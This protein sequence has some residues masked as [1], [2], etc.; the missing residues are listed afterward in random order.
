MTV[1][2]SDIRFAIDEKEDKWCAYL[3][4]EASDG[5]EVMK[6]IT[7]EHLG[8]EVVSWGLDHFG[9][10]A[11]VLSLGN[12]PFGTVVE[13][14]IEGD[15]DKYKGVYCN[16][17]RMYLREAHGKQ[18]SAYGTCT[19]EY[20]YPKRKEGD[21]S[22]INVQDIISVV[23][24][25]FKVKHQPKSIPNRKE[26]GTFYG[27]SDRIA[28]MEEGTS[29]CFKIIPWMYCLLTISEELLPIANN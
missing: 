16:N 2:L 14:P 15:Y 25:R 28:V 9:P 8:L 26:T 21:E 27:Q 18:D 1:L 6:K 19:I 13:L 3:L 10:G 5:K 23:F 7:D 4:C 11:P 24:E 20:W 29:K 12:F 22:P 17:G